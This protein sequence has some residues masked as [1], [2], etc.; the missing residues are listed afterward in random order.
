MNISRKHI[1]SVTLVVAAT[2]ALFVA[3]VAPQEHTV[4]AC[5]DTIAI[6][7]APRWYSPFVVRIEGDKLFDTVSFKA[8]GKLASS[9]SARQLIF[10][11]LAEALA[12]NLRQSDGL[13]VDTDVD[14]DAFVADPAS[15][16]ACEGHH[17]YV[18]FW[19]RAE[20]AMGW[21]FSLW[22][23]CDADS[24]FA[25]EELPIPEDLNKAEAQYLLAERIAQR[26]SSAMR[27]GCV[28]STC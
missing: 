9:D 26:L 8:V 20:P 6:T 3:M 2:G 28:D 5:G 16:C 7:D 4:S 10:E 15:H 13:T 22:S 21:G 25:W 12:E 23:G 11:N 18:D 24:Q 14:F 19:R 17:T 1:A 27:N